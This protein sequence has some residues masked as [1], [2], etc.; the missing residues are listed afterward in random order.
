[1]SVERP[2]RGRAAAQ[3]TDRRNSLRLNPRELGSLLDEFDAP[4]EG[5]PSGQRKF[6]RRPFRHDSL[7][8]LVCPPGGS[9]TRITM[10]CRNIS[11]TGLSVLHNCYMHPGTRC[12]V[13]LPHPTRGQVPVAGSVGRCE[14]RSGMVHEI[15]IKFSEPIE[16]REFIHADPFG[17]CYSLESFKPDELKGSIV[18]VDDCEMDVRILKHFLRGTALAVRTAGNIAD[19][20]ALLDSRPDLVITDYDLPDGTGLD[21]TGA[22]RQRGSPAPVILLTSDTGDATRRALAAAPPDACLAKP[23]TQNLLQRAIGEFLIVKSKGSQGQ[24]PTGP[25]AETAALVQTFVEALPRCVAQLNAAVKSSDAA[26]AR[27]QCLRIAGTAP[28]VGFAHLGELAQVAA[29][30]LAASKSVPASLKPIQAL[31]AACER[32]RGRNAA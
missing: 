19:A 28:S 18:Y 32:A 16:V 1:M 5:R 11:R 2:A 7:Q 6:V 26:Q 24:A 17:D 21:L 13:L 10:A 20:I 8:V 30:T 27:S 15:G 9:P 14:H 29:R 3:Q 4:E 25:D 31:I 22:I 12:T 23:L